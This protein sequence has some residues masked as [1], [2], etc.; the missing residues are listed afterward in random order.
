MRMRIKF[1]PIPSRDKW[2]KRWLRKLTFGRFGYEWWERNMGPREPTPVE[3][4]VRRVMQKRVFV[5]QFGYE[6]WSKI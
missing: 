2:W 1:I 6:A 3:A 4:M 5:E